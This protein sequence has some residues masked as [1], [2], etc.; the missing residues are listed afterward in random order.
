M[1]GGL[2][3]RKG[4]YGDMLGLFRR[5]PAVTA[6]AAAAGRLAVG[7]G[8]YAN[9]IR[10]RR[11]ELA[12]HNELLRRPPTDHDSVGGRNKRQSRRAIRVSGA[13]MSH[14]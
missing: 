11:L 4:D 12:G 13:W 3:R 7:Y 1:K 6:G 5:P 14:T 9:G 2:E 10:G 8:D